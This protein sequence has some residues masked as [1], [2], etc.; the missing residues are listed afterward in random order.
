MKL[1]KKVI[2]VS[3]S[4][5]NSDYKRYWLSKSKIEILNHIDELRKINYRNKASQRLQKILEV[6]KKVI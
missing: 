3:S 2:S 6:V 4:F 5:D 1:N